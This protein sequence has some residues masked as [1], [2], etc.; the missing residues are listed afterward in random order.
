[1]LDA[2]VLRSPTLDGWTV[3]ANYL[4]TPW[5]K[6]TLQP[7]FR[8]Y[9]QTDNQGG[10]LTRVAP[11]VR[12]VYRLRERFSI[13]GEANVERTRSSSQLVE[14]LLTRPFFYIGWHWDF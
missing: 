6:F 5:Q 10:R 2:S 3:G 7:T 1:M 13:E 4:F 14:D 9:H 8:Y 12:V 11:G